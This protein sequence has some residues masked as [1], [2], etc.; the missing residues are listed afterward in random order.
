VFGLDASVQQ[1]RS[2]DV[3]AAPD[4]S[5]RVFT[6][7]PPPAWPVYFLDLRVNTAS[8]QPLSSNFYWLAAK[9]DELDW[10]KSTWYG[11]PVKVYADLTPLGALRPTTITTTVTNR[12]RAAAGEGETHVALV[13]TGKSI[14]FFVRLQVTK[15]PGGDE[16]LPAFWEDN[17]VSLIPGEKRDIVV[18]YRL[19]DLGNAQPAVKVAGWNVR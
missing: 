1:S 10:P 2:V 7:Q 19:A 5:T 14:A 12:R 9:M 13:N 4:S 11:T 15:G 8:G 3:D 6:I 18:A 17:Y 16:I